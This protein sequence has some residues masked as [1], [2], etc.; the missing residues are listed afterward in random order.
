[1]AIREQLKQDLAA[2]MRAKDEV[3]RDTIRMLQAA[4][5]NTELESRQK[6][7]QTIFAA[8]QHDLQQHLA[9][10]QGVEL[11]AFKSRVQN[12]S[13]DEL[14]AIKE[15]L[16]IRRTAEREAIIADPPSLSD[17]EI[18][19][20]IR[21][22]IKQRR[23]SIEAYDKA[24]RPELAAAERA[25]LAVLLAYLPEQPFSEQELRALVHQ[26]IAEVGATGPREMGK[27]MGALQPRIKDRAD[28]R[29]ASQMVKDLLA[30]L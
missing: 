25:E 9:G 5:K 28:G 17:A 16:G 6:Q 23:D 18:T 15:E 24:N 19:D 2:A 10:L 22:Q 27:V 13:D 14:A 1:M 4:V 3:R 12:A 8:E 29:A 11:V 30:S 7:M 26:V 21:R 20:V